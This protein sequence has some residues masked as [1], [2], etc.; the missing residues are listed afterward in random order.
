MLVA[1]AKLKEVKMPIYAIDTQQLEALRKA[2]HVANDAE[3]ARRMGVNKS[4]VSRVLSGKGNPG[5]KFREGLKD[6][7]PGLDIDTVIKR[8]A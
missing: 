8:A 1:T 5:A 3:L 2:T 6:A 4:T 7:F